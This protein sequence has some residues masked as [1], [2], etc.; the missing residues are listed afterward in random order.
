[1][2]K[3]VISAFLLMNAI[4]WGIF[5]PSENSPHNKLLIILVINYTFDKYGHL[6]IGTCF[7]IVGILLGQSSLI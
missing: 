7:Y 5:P 2:L 3:I 4:F 1:M 6:F